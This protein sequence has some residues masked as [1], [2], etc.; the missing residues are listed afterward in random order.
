VSDPS[1]FITGDAITIFEK[2]IKNAAAAVAREAK[3]RGAAVIVL[4]LP[5][6]MDGSEGAR[7]AKSRELKV[8]IEEL[9]E[10]P[11]KLWDERLT[12]VQAHAVL[13]GAGKKEKKHKNMVDAV[14]ASLILES[15]LG[16]AKPHQP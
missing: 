7:A 5:K 11:V 9:C 10:I 6:N 3:E 15:Y 14:A 2:H 13:R 12:T 1:G 8:L 4:G 16:A